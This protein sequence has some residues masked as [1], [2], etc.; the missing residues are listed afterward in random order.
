M[1]TIREDEDLDPPSD[2]QDP[3]EADEDPAPP[4]QDIESSDDESSAGDWAELEE[5]DEPYMGRLA[6]DNDFFGSIWEACLLTEENPLE[7]AGPS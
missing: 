3:E 1:F 5:F 4:L 7:G 2:D 6:K